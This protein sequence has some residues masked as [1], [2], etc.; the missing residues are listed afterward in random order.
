MLHLKWRF[1][2][3][4][5]MEKK[6]TFPNVT[7]VFPVSSFQ[8]QEYDISNVRLVLWILNESKMTKWPVTFD[9]IAASFILTC[10][11]FSVIP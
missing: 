8:H 7:K 6:K 10:D 5:D 9:E 3:C 11:M 2:W 4:N 1:E